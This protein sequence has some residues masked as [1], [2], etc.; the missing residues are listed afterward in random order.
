MPPSHVGR[1][2][3]AVMGEEKTLRWRIVGLRE[4]LKEDNLRRMKKAK[5]RITAPEEVKREARDM[6]EEGK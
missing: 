1:E 6:Y 3:N 5:E 2:G 4:E